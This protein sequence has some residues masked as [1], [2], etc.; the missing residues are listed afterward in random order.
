MADYRMKDLTRD[1]PMKL[2]LSF[3]LPML[4]GMLFQKFYNMVD[5]VVV[6]SMEKTF[7]LSVSAILRLQIS[8]ENV[9]TM[10]FLNPCIVKC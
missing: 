3:M 8:R 5:T 1:V 7:P 9:G 2:L 4:L 6:P 10:S